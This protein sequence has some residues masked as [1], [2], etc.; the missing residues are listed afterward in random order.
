M[1]APL[2]WFDGV[3][4]ATL[5]LSAAV[6]LRRGLVPE[7]LAL[8]GW[9]VAFFVAGWAAP[10]VAVALPV[11][12]PGGPLNH[13]AAFVLAFLACLALWWFVSRVPPLLLRR[14]PPSG[15]ER[16]LAAVFGTFRGLVLLLALATAVG[17]T[18]AAQSDAWQGS[19]IAHGLGKAVQGLRPLL[20]HALVPGLPS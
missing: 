18:P 13:A 15:P 2:P 8:A 20:P 9:F 3:F 11:G 1:N 14:R 16:A 6:G 4:A 10:K 19:S 5:V 17:L 12:S 7:L